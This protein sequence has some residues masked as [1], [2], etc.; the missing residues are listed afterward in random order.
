MLERIR[1]LTDT[2]EERRRIYQV[3]VVL[4]SILTGA[5]I[6]TE[7]WGAQILALLSAVAP[8]VMALA[9]VPQSPPPAPDESPS[10]SERVDSP[11]E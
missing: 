2:P 1:E 10:V 7:W 4:V 6:L 5:G 9:H 8:L 3:A 11:S